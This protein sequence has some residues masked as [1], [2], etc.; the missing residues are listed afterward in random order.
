MTLMKKK[1]Y[2]WQRKEL[3]IE[4][5]PSEICY[6]KGD[7]FFSS[8]YVHTNMHTNMHTHEDGTTMN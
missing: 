3:H 4:G 7:A 5:S 6:S 2:R 8:K 1:Q